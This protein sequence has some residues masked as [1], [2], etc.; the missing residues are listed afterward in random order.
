VW[1][2]QIGLRGILR[3]SLF[4]DIA[5]ISGA[6]VGGGSLVYAATLYPESVCAVTARD[7]H[8]DLSDGVTITSSVWPQPDTHFEPFGY[9][10]ALD[11]MSLY[12]VPLTGDGTRVTRPLKLLR[13]V[14]RHPRDTALVSNPRGWSRRSMSVGAMQSSEGVLRF[15]YVPRRIGRGVRL[16]TRQD[17][18]H[19]NPTFI[20]EL[21][22]AIEVMADQ[23]DA[24]AQSWVT[25]ALFNI[26]F[27][28]HILGGAV[29]GT[30]PD[31]GVIDSRHQVH[32]YRN[33]LVCDGSAVPGNPGVNPS[34]TIAAMTERAMCRVPARDPGEAVALMGSVP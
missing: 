28:A 16:K 3:M 11:S 31:R 19:P 2:P 4:R 7:P 18:E 32:G 10:G 34:L 17:P 24:V 5:I 22:E 26:P 14:I 21:Y 30:G 8:A 15:E 1:A 25:E 33:L 27:T 12:F 23:L 9:G 6:G 13:N 29:I 20:P